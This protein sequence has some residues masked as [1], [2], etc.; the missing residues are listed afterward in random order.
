MKEDVDGISGTKYIFDVCIYAK[1]TQN[2]VAVG[3]E[4]DKKGKKADSKSLKNFLKSIKDISGIEK[5]IQR[6]YY[7][8]SFG[9]EDNDPMELVKKD[10][11]INDITIR[12]LE[13][14]DKVFLSLNSK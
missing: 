4:N 1:D 9:Y 6:V 8:S 3:I 5:H 12:F 2:L 10:Y 7:V 14:K 11:R 13:F